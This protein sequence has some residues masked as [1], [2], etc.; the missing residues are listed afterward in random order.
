[1]QTCGEIAQG[2]RLSWTG[3]QPVA[4]LTLLTFCICPCTPPQGASNQTI[5]MWLKFR[6]LAL[7]EWVSKS[8]ALTVEELLPVFYTLPQVLKRNWTN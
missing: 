7:I 2:Y 4:G 3:C 1:M 8:T 5:K 6:I